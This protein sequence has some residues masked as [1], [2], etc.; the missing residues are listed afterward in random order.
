VGI[1]VILIAETMSR[2]RLGVWLI[3]LVLRMN[4]MFVKLELVKETLGNALV[5]YGFCKSGLDV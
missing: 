5:S 3:V 4:R 2:M 1:L